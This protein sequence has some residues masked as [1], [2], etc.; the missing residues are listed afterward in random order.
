MIQ[1]AM[2]M[3]FAIASL[4]LPALVARGELDKLPVEPT[5]PPELLESDG[6]QQVDATSRPLD[7]PSV[8]SHKAPSNAAQP[9]MK[10]LRV[11]PKEDWRS[12]IQRMTET[13]NSRRTEKCNGFVLSISNDVGLRFNYEGDVTGSGII[14]DGQ[15]H[16]VLYVEFSPAGIRSCPLQGYDVAENSKHGGVCWQT[17]EMK[18]WSW[19]E[20][21]QFWAALPKLLQG[22]RNSLSSQKKGTL[23]SELAKGRR[24]VVFWGADKYPLQAYWPSFIRLHTAVGE[25]YFSLVLREG[26][27]LYEDPATTAGGTTPSGKDTAPQPATA[28]PPAA[29][30]PATA[31][32]AVTPPPASTPASRK[33]DREAPSASARP[34]EAAFTAPDAAAA[35]RL[36]KPKRPRPKAPKPEP[37]PAPDAPAQ[38]ENTPAPPAT[39]PAETNAPAAPEAPAPAAPAESAAT[40][41]PAAP[42]APAPAAQG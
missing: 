2:K 23:R 28:T 18:S 17:G 41:P 42:E 36:A 32:E 9:W 33:A 35:A 16:D 6:K 29:A 24:M 21:E 27:K 4:I 10:L 15:Y 34:A 3:R 37:A 11:S 26:L 20:A 8:V 5:L 38:A 40:P 7:M 25:P 22:R 31:P 39:P 1:S 14:A 13:Y 30:P 19:A 12:V